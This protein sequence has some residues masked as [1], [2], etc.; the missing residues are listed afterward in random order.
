MKPKPQV[1]PYKCNICGLV[2]VNPK[3]LLKHKIVL[4]GD[5]IY[6]CQSCNKIFDT[7]YKFENHLAE[8][9][10]TSQNTTAISAGYE[11]S[12]SS[13]RTM[14]QSVEQDVDN[15]MESVFFRKAAQ[16]KKA[17]KRIRGPYRKSVS[18]Q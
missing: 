16:E 12:E 10:D 1:K 8:I 14:D 7:K 2:L 18:S 11:N 13:S 15:N 6:Q 5:R 3:E 17:R 9:H 4:H